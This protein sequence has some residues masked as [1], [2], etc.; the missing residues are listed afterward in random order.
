MDDAWKRLARLIGGE[1]LAADPR[2]H[3]TV[4]RNTHREEILRCI[5]EWVMAQPSLKDC[6]AALDAAGVPCAPVQRIDQVVA[7]PQVRA[8]GM[9]FEQ[10]HPV[11]GRVVLPNVPFRFSDADV[12]PRTPA[13]LLGQHNRGILCTIL[14]YSAAQVTE[15]E[16][17]A[18]LHAE[19]AAGRLPRNP[20][21]PK[22]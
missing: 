14:G 18:V 4:G 19:E 22:A 13:P 8:R 16:R 6:A 12:T 7:D 9:L 5:R 20:A 3:D 21:E 17:D 11:L 10:E 2:F 15:M 1:G